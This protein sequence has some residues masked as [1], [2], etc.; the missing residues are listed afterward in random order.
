MS[1]PT[2][3]YP[4]TGAR[5]HRFF[6]T[7]FLKS[8]GHSDPVPVGVNDWDTPLS[9]EHPVPVV[10]LHGTWMNAYGTWS[11]IAPAL[12][13]RGYRVF[14]LNYGSNDE[15]FLGRRTCCFANGGLLDSSVEIA[16]FIDTVL[17]RTG[18][19]QVDVIG[20]S[21]GGA[22]ARLLATGHD[23]RFAGDSPKIRNVI[24]LAGSGHGTTMMG[25]GTMAAWLR[26]KLRG[27]VDVSAVLRAVLGQ[28]AEDQIVGSDVVQHINRHGDTVPGVTFTMI[29][30][31]YDEVVTPWRTQFL[32]AG[33]GATVHNF[34]VQ[35]D[36]NAR[37]WSDHLSVCYSPRTV[38]LI[39]ERLTDSDSA[40][41]GDSGSYRDT[42]PHVVA[43]VLPVLGMVGRK[44]R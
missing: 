24:E 38:D 16:E 41:S 9:E 30:T 27:K 44:G 6:L 26:E 23:G 18:A 22:Q 5:E 11:M 15:S 19:Q 17:E 12:A 3:T 42:H 10:L 20:H 32:D 39:L 28:C 40:A 7:A 8:W 37:D 35:S 4:V 33:D 43:R 2:N 21:Q 25:L 36:G 13:S 1:S 29:S 34:C 14:A 31:R